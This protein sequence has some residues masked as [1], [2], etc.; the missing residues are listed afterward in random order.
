M[1]E[2]VYKVYHDYRW[3]QSMIDELNHG[4]FPSHFPEDYTHVA[5]V[6][7]NGLREAVDLTRD[8]GGI[9]DD[10]RTWEPW[11]KNGKAE[12][13]VKAPR[14]TVSG[15]VIVDPGGKAYQLRGENFTEIRYYEEMLEQVAQSARTDR[16]IE[17]ERE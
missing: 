13:L 6:R 2:K 15:D 9:L 7:A 14:D 8:V 3:P 1:M 16:D 12:A 11:E 4:A 10:T 5:N 17:R